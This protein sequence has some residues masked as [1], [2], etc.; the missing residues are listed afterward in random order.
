MKDYNMTV[1]YHSDK[2]YVVD[3]SLSPLSMGSVTS[4]EEE[5]KEFVRD[6]YILDGLGM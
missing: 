1:L 2:A 3:D 6:V 5:N 4:M